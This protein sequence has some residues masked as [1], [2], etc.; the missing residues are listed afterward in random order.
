MYILTKQLLTQ[1]KTKRPLILNLTNDVSMSLIANGLLSL[2][3][4]PIM[5]QAPEE[6]DDLLK[7]T[8]GLV[9]NI[10]TLNET[11]IR[12]CEK[13]CATAN[14][15]DIPITFD[16]V[17]VGASQYR[18]STC[19]QFLERFKFAVIRGNASEIMAIAGASQTTKGVDSLHETQNAI[20]SGQYLASKHS[21]IIAISGETDAV[22]DDNK[23][24]LFKR[25]SP[26][27]PMITG[28]GCLLTSVTSAFHSVHHDAYEAVAAAVYF[29]S[30]CGEIASQKSNGPG[31]FLPHFIDALSSTPE[32]YHYESL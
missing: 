18:T 22:I 15:L 27:M 5:S 23:V 3:A 2:G 32:E 19:L 10:G 30:L 21:A 1:I 26:I 24:Q 9:I 17:G 14:A 20:K 16:P 6:I 29:Y 11:F 31:S 7:I 8:N 28:S 12:L 25:G 13:A 4:S